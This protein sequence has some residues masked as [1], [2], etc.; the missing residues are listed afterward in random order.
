MR[1]I[2]VTNWN[3][4]I[5]EE[6][7]VFVLGDAVMGKRQDSLEV[8]SRLNGTKVLVPGN[9]DD[10]HPMYKDKVSYERKLEMYTSVF[11]VTLIHSDSWMIR[12]EVSDTTINMCHFPYLEPKKLDYQGRDFSEWQLE[13]D[14]KVL[15]CGH[16]HD[17]WAEKRTP[18][19][20][21][22]INVGVDVRNFTPIS[23]EQV[24]AITNSQKDIS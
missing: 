3:G 19:G 9:H 11:D 20:T 6:D 16:V 23:F 18:Q 12:D 15:L 14:G 13:D 5:G 17:T 22:M 2:M 7:T 21:L 4:V 8:F 24:L 10:C 1:E